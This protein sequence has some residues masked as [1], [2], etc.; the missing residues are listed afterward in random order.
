MNS[1]KVHFKQALKKQIWD[2]LLAPVSLL[3]VIVVLP[4]LILYGV[5]W[6]IDGL[7]LNYR[8]RSRYASDGKYILFVYSES[9]NWQEYIEENIIPCIKTKAV[10]LNWSK[11]SEWKK[12]K[13]L[14]AKALLHWGGDSEFNPMAIIF[15]SGWKVQ[16]IRFYQAFK[17]FKHGKSKLLREK[18][19]ELYAYLEPNREVR[20]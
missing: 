15:V 4:F 8:F 16:T 10:L 18:E 1:N 12:R 20:S 11:R 5:W 6:L 17:D 3:L 2:I 14:E 13:P 9:P 19:E 7:W